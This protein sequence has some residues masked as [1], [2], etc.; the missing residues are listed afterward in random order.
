MIIILVK[1]IVRLYFNL[2]IEMSMAEADNHAPS[3]D[4][5]L[6]TTHCFLSFVK[7]MGLVDLNGVSVAEPI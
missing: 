3:C 6:S 7:M 1:T 4:V 5:A 2:N